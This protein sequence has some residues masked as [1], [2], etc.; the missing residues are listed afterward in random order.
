M[1]KAVAKNAPLCILSILIPDGFQKVINPKLEEVIAYELGTD[2]ESPPGHGTRFCV[3]T[4]AC[5][6]VCKVTKSGSFRKI[7]HRFPW[8]SIVSFRTE[9]ASSLLVLT[10][11]NNTTVIQFSMW[12]QFASAIRG[13]LKVFLAN[14]PGFFYQPVPSEPET[15]APATRHSQ[16]VNLFLS[17]AYLSN[18]RLDQKLFLKFAKQL[19]NSDELTIDPSQ[20]FDASLI[21]LADVL[22]YA[23]GITTVRLGGKA[24]E[25][26]WRRLAAIIEL[27]PSIRRLEIFETNAAKEFSTFITKLSAR[28]AVEELSFRDVKFKDQAKTL[29][30]TLATLPVTQ[31]AF[32]GCRFGSEILPEV[33]RYPGCFARLKN[34]RIANDSIGVKSV[35]DLLTS[36]SGTGI[37]VFAVQDSQLDLQSFFQRLSELSGTLDLTAIDLSGNLCPAAFTG[38]ATFPNKLTRLT[39]RRVTWDGR[40]LVDFLA[41]QTFFSDLTI[42]LSEA[43]I[44]ESQAARVFQDLPAEPRAPQYTGLIWESNFLSTKL[45]SFFSKQTHLR[46]FSIANCSIPRTERSAIIRQLVILIGSIQLTTL[47]I[48]RTFISIRGAW[49]SHLKEVLAGH[50]TLAKLDISFNPI[51]TEGASILCDILRAN[52]HLVY[53]SFDGIELASAEDLIRLFSTIRTF[54]YVPRIQRPTVEMDRL[55]ARAGHQTCAEVRAAWKRLKGKMVTPTRT[56]QFDDSVG[57]AMGTSDTTSMSLMSVAP[58][59]EATWDVQ[60]DIPGGRAVAEWE[61]LRRRFTYEAIAGVSTGGK[62]TSSA[63]TG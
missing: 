60:I 24:F 55:T 27:N 13:Y 31:L 35:N 3:A 6:Y 38:S 32:R 23:T 51:G 17:Q 9:N 42:D 11:S 1:A 4:A 30:S 61:E 15:V 50:D 26:L 47:D 54:P 41:R 58:H 10:F 52:P 36:V 2:P 18:R 44:S 29:I 16:I 48:S 19:R 7:V 62:P 14:Y 45:V 12:E 53:V 39:L 5:Y 25:N 37:E 43:I 34:L 22:V 59:L 49:F 21:P 40:S 20:A 8:L 28:Q 63:G 57:D 33:T 56:V 46:T